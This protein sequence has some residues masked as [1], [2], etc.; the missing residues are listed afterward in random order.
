MGSGVFSSIIVYH[1]F[2]VMG[3]IPCRLLDITINSVCMELLWDSWSYG[4]L[5]DVFHCL[6]G[7]EKSR[8]PIKL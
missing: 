5:E 8:K 1:N 3:L 6:F 7:F 2:F 4:V